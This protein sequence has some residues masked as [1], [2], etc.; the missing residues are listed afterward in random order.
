MFNF[1]VSILSAVQSLA[2][3]WLTTVMRLISD[4]FLPE[5]VV[6]IIAII[7]VVLLIR[8]KRLQEVLLIL[9]MA[10]NVWSLILKPIIHRP[11]PTVTQATIYAPE[12]DFSMPSAHALE[13]MTIGGAIIL[14]DKK[15]RKAT[16]F[17]LT[18][19]VAAF[20]LLVGLSRVYLGV[21]FPSDVLAGYLIGW[22]WLLFVWR[23]VRPR[24]EK[25]YKK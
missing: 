22:F 6:P 7:L 5:V 18:T 1:D 14:L 17:W 2:A 15:K 4:I 9:I 10:G 3:P 20:V 25:V 12:T 16:P 13:V 8:H 24:L 19:I 23:W 21:H 11:R